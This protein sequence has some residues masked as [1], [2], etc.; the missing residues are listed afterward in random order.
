MTVLRVAKST[1]AGIVG[2]ILSEFVDTTAWMPR[3]HTRA[4]ELESAALMI[5]L[6]W[7]TI[8]ETNGEA[9]GFMALNGSELN[10]LYVAQTARGQGV[11]AALLQQA[12]ATAQTI[13][14]WTFQ[15]NTGAQRFYQ[16]HEFGEISRSDGSSNDEGLSDVC[17]IWH[18]KDS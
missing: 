14:V 16:R 17:L 12:Q 5:D 10:A 1:D 7:V 8:A 3:L 13:I 2:G 11:G 18:R 4:E 6:G 15:A 9:V